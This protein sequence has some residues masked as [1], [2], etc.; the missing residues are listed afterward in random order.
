MIQ[1]ENSGENIFQAKAEKNLSGNYVLT[2]DINLKNI[3]GYK[4]RK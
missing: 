3:G 1:L 2:G 4:F